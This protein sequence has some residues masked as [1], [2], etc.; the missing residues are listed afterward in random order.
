MP[1]LPDK[2]PSYGCAFWGA[3]GVTVALWLVPLGGLVLWPFSILATWAHEMGHGWM[4]LLLGGEFDHLELYWGGGGV[5]H[6]AASEPWQRA[7]Y[8]SAGLIGAPMAGVATLMIGSYRKAVVPLLGA[9]V[10]ALLISSAVWVRT[11]FGIVAC[12]SIA[13]GIAFLTWKLSPPK[14]FLFVQFLGIQLSLSAFRSLDYMFSSEARFGTYDAIPSDTAL[15]AE[16][17]GGTYFIWG[18]VIAVLDLAMLYGAYRFVS[19]RMSREE[20]AEAAA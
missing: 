1:K 17:I 8:S 11:V 14:R 9:L 6:V 13:A 7:L 12:V 4:A 19:W 2:A 20:K 10:V 18:L 16:A 3:V 5:A 15:I